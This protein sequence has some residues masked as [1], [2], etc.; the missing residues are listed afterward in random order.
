MRIIQGCQS[1][2]FRISSYNIIEPLKA[3]LK[4][5]NSQQYSHSVDKP[6]VYQTDRGPIFQNVSKWL[7]PESRW[8]CYYKCMKLLKILR[9]KLNRC[10]PIFQKRAKCLKNT[11][12]CLFWCEKIFPLPSPTI[13]GSRSTIQ[14]VDFGSVV[15]PIGIFQKCTK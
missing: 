9:N 14:V 12:E 7:Y 10:G 8:F 4:P 13:T 1:K 11:S 3:N 2:I 6:G 15:S 5:K